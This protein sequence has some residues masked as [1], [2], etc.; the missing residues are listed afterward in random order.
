MF[1]KISWEYK[2]CIMNSKK[3]LEK[4]SVFLY[5]DKNLTTPVSTIWI[6]LRCS[7]WHIFK[8]FLVCFVD[9][10]SPN[11][12][13]W[14][15][16]ECVQVWH[17]FFTFIVERYSSFVFVFPLKFYL[18]TIYS[19]CSLSIRI[20]LK[21]PGTWGSTLAI[22]FFRLLKANLTSNFPNWSV[23]CHNKC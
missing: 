14:Y 17:L 4:C 2:C 7:K 12:H 21:F 13:W 22:S 1:F 16:V 9:S 10:M 19:Q 6:L 18:K 11:T 5:L 15:C 23:E 8:L 3:A 20:Y